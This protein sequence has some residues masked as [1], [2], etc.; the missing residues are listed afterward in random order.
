MTVP[1]IQ[2]TAVKSACIHGAGARGCCRGAVD[3]DGKAINDQSGYSVSLSADRTV[4]A[5]GAPF[6]DGS[7]NVLDSGHVRVYGWNG[8][9][10]I[11]RGQDIEGE[12]GV[13]T[14]MTV[15]TAGAD[16]GSKNWNIVSMSS[17]GQYQ[18]SSVG[19]GYIYTSYDFGVTWTQR[20]SYRSW[21][22]ISL[23][24]TGQY[25]SAIEQSS[26]IYTSYDF[27]VNW[28]PRKNDVVGIGIVFPYHPPGSIKVRA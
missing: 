25:Q 28:V 22:G 1:E 20:D 5:I 9:D 7:E 2:S 21:K 4:M 27:G 6:S 11:K 14:P 26:Y 13:A 17:T 18:S 23:S 12:A 15:V 16:S 8:T 19:N 3:T 10:W 24:S